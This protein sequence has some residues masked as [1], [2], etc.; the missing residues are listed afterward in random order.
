[1]DE[2]CAIDNNLSGF[3]DVACAEI[4]REVHWGH[5]FVSKDVFRYLLTMVMTG[6]GLE[7]VGVV[8]L[9]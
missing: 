1:M 2:S 5:G 4:V 7:H 6:F 9:F 8:G 3:W